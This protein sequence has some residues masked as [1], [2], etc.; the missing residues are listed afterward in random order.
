MHTWIN[1]RIT[2]TSAAT[3]SAADLALNRG[4]GVF[5]FIRV[6][7][8]K[9][10]FIEE[11]LGRLGASAATMRLPLPLELPALVD[12]V[13]E[14]AGLHSY[15]LSGIRLTLTGGVSGDGY[16]IGSPG[17]IITDQALQPPAPNAF[18]SGIRLLSIDHQR[19]LP[20]VK[21]IDYLFPIWM[22]P[23]MREAGADD[24]LYHQNG[25]VSECPRSNVFIVTAEGVLVTP[26][27]KIL[28]GVTRSMVLDCAR[29]RFPVEERNVTLDEVEAA[30]E[31]FITS[32]TKEILPVRMLDARPLR[33]GDEVTRALHRLLRDRIDAYVAG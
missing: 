9:P 28:K 11:H 17:L 20:Q 13:R 29:G 15:P 27:N 30:A 4:Y 19:Q 6:I 32:T 10:V 25:T 26:Q 2:P 3:I 16:S 12:I 14:L 24:L 33:T 22:Q 1:G 5:D 21:S 23:Q 8:G 31:V 7:N 18:E